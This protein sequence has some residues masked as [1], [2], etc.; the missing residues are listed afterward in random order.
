MEKK[1]GSFRELVCMV[2]LVSKKISRGKSASSDIKYSTMST[3]RECNR[4]ENNSELHYGNQAKSTLW[5]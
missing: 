4:P 5:K 3:S 1:K 2:V